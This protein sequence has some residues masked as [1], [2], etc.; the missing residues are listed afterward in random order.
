MS[1][2]RRVGGYIVFIADPIYVGVN[3][4]VNVSMALNS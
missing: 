1:P 3:I 2:D 4:L